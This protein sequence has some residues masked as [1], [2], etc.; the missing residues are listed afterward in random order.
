DMSLVPFRKTVGERIPYRVGSIDGMLERLEG[1]IT[2]KRTVSEILDL[3]NLPEDEVIALISMLQKHNWI[4]F[5]RRLSDTDTLERG[6]CA[7]IVLDRLKAQYGKPLEELIAG[8]KEPSVI[9]DVI[10]SL[11]YDKMAMWFLI[12]KLVELGCFSQ[13]TT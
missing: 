10:D 11:P 1:F 7:Q 4:D 2:G 5:K 13:K 3:I 8:F 12:N 6:D 9:K